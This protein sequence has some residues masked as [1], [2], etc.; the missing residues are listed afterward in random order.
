MPNGNR[1][2]RHH[3]FYAINVATREVRLL[4]VTHADGAWALNLIRAQTAPGAGFL[5]GMRAIIMDRDPLFTTQVRDCL[6]AV[7]CLPKV[8]PPRSPN[9]NA[10]I[11]RF[12]G[13][14]VVSV[15][16]RK[17]DQRRSR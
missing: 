17:F 2:Q 14:V 7:G 16:L 10:Y 4:G 12:I 15:K 9:L 8:L 5:S 6:A 3:A 11:E 1:T 13:T